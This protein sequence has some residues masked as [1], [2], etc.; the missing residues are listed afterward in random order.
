MGKK[1]EGKLENYGR[2]LG[3]VA[4]KALHIKEIREIRRGGHGRGRKGR[5]SGRTRPRKNNRALL[6]G[7][8]QGALFKRGKM[9]KT[10][11]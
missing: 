4:W 1:K 9:T 11:S 8:R 2:D 10:T 5:K 7:G 3:R 6:G